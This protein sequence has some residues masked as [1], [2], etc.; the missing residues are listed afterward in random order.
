[1]ASKVRGQIM[2]ARGRGRTNSGIGSD[3]PNGPGPA[4]QGIGCLNAKVVQFLRAQ[5]QLKGVA[6]S[7]RH[8]TSRTV[9]RTRNT[10]ARVTGT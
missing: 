3:L 10:D 9:R 5:I 6:E 4:V 1:M 8:R 7:A 2:E